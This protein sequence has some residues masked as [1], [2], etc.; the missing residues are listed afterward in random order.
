[1]QRRLFLQW[2]AALALTGCGKLPRLGLPIQVYYPGM[3]AGH[4][5]RDKPST[6]PPTMRLKVGTVIVGSGIG[7]LM[8]AWKLWREGYRDLLLISGP[9]LGGNA[10]GGRFG[11]IPYP[12]GAH[13]LPL[14]SL[15][16]TH[17]REM[18]QDV[19]VIE[20]DAFATHP[21]YDE[22]AILHGPEDRLLCNGQWQDGIMPTHGVDENER[23]QQQRFV[24]Q[25]ET[26]RHAMGADGRRAFA[27]PIAQASADP[28]WRR[29][30]RLS[31]K[32]WLIQQR[33]TAPSLHWY[34]NYCCRDDY[35]ADYDR[36]SAWAGLHY[37]AARGGHAANAA[38]GVLLT[39]P[40]GLHDLAKKLMARLDP[41]CLLAGS[42]FRLVPT[43]QGVDAWIQTEDGRT[44]RIQA[45]HGVCALPLHVAKHIIP[46][47][48]D[49]GFHPIQHM[50][51]HAPWLVSNFLLDG[52]PAEPEHAPLAWDNVVYQG[53][54]L[55]WV[56]ATHQWIRAAKPEQTVFTAYHALA[57]GEPA[58]TRR[59]L[60]KASADELYELAA[61]DLEQA[62]G[63]RLRRHLKQLEITVRGHAMASPTVGFLDNPG[64]TALRQGWG[65]LH[66]AHADLSGY[67][68]CEE[69]AW[70]GY[71][72]AHRV[73]AG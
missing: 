57:D 19:G 67:S 69:A 49:S 72:A 32:A 71:Q 40:D 54:G 6:S 56:V 60:Q 15:E 45:D 39:W 68:V 11:N 38:D 10:A 35:G 20:R 58:D 16:S 52:F 66:F 26:L 1:M 24:D 48:A 7:G 65:R 18:L 17:I 25:M 22:T 36:I 8:A 44:L 12:R 9:E 3:Q 37:F 46:N 51:L 29:L 63:W 62:Y 34:A 31:F 59:W 4:I 53:R 33:Y 14:P 70:W 2:T 41:G 61:C 5:L 50:P 27:I 28:V 47:L 30:D 55:G 73:L 13:Y 42:A 43:T 64:L 21:Y 23:M